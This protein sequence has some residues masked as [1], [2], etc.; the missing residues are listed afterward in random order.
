MSRL[1]LALVLGLSL[2]VVAC[3]RAEGPAEEMGEDMEDTAEDA[4]DAVD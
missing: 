1:W 4:E 3:D 2:G